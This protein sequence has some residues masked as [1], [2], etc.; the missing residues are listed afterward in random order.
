[1]TV[2]IR[3]QL[4]E[5][6]TVHWHGLEVPGEVDGGPQGVIKAGGSRT[7]TFTPT[8]QAATCWFH[9]HQHGKTGRQVAMGLAGLVLIEDENS[10]KLR[11]PQQ[12]GIDDVPVIVQDKKLTAQGRLITSSM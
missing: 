5:E 11:L 3:N 6:T 10:R 9:P 8:Q 12:W 4:A 7:V 2:D 1:M